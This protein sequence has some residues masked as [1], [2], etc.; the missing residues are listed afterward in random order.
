MSNKIETNVA[1]IFFIFVLM[2]VTDP[3][4]FYYVIHKCDKRSLS[5][6]IHQY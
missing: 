5:R 6:D 4:A 2:Y 1:R 3:V